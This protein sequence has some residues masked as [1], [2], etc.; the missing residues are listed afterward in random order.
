MVAVEH[1][2]ATLIHI[3]KKKRFDS[4]KFINQSSL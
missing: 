1:N 3:V 4:E 2:L